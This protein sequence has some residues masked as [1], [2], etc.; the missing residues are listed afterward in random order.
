MNKFTIACCL[1]WSVALLTW[2]FRVPLADKLSAIIPSFNYVYVTSN[3]SLLVKYKQQDATHLSWEQLMPVTERQIIEKYQ[4]PIA[5]NFAEQ[6]LLSINA[7][8]DETYRDAMFSTNVVEAL[9]G[10][11][12]AVSGF[13]VPLELG[14]EQLLTSFFLVPYFGACI[15]YPPPPPNQM[16]FV[17]VNS[18]MKIP[19]INI[20]Y[21]VIGVLKQSLYEDV[22]GT[23]AYQFDLISIE[24]F[25][26]QADDFGQHAY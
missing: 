13:I 18:P 12:S 11:Q 20:A 26:G 23:S 21:T 6:I 1:T 5:M 2:H 8:T 15:H 25:T 16:I 19:D 14:S 4:Q 9:L 10:K 3:E 22:L 7:S 24:Q 17:R